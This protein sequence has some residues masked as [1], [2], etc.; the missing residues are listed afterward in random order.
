[1]LNRGPIRKHAEVIDMKRREHRTGQASF[2]VILCGTLLLGAL[3]LGARGAA[4]VDGS[5]EHA[6]PRGRA[7]ALPEPVEPAALG[8]LLMDQPDTYVVFDVRPTWQFDE[9]HVP[10]ARHAGLDEIADRIR[11]LDPALRPVIVDRDGTVAFA[12]G[13]AVL[14][15]LGKAQRSIRVLA[16]GTARFWRDVELAPRGMGGPG[17]TPPRIDS[18]SEHRI[19]PAGEAPATAAKKRNPGC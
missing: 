11:E 5:P 4:H 19:A 2:P 13:G 15:R 16:G 3:G 6:I 9:Y 10:G 18:N 17:E 12:V 7:I 1:V 8:E 14:E